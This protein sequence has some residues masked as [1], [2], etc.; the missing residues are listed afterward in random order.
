[1]AVVLGPFRVSGQQCQPQRLAVGIAASAV[2]DRDQNGAQSVQDASRQ[3]QAQ[4][5]VSDH[6]GGGQCQDGNQSDLSGEGEQQG[7][8]QSAVDKGG[9]EERE[10]EEEFV[11]RVPPFGPFVKVNGR[12]QERN[13]AE[14][15]T[16]E[17]D[18]PPI[19]P[20]R[21]LGEEGGVDAVLQEGL[22]QVPEAVDKH[23]LVDDDYLQDELR[24]GLNKALNGP[25]VVRFGDPLGLAVR[26]DGHDDGVNVIEDERNPV[27]AGFAAA[28]AVDASSQELRDD[29]E[30][31]RQTDETQDGQ[32]VD[33]VV[34]EDEFDS[35]GDIG[36]DVR[37]EEGDEEGRE[38]G[39]SGPH[40]VKS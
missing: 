24:Y 30:H 27:G 6:L 23:A 3:V 22:E 10:E 12:L 21:L 4:A 31:D 5:G 18:Q 34:V 1:M 36:E 26:A 32:T 39:M 15:D 37:H 2:S 8:G 35:G 16:V 20:Q 14:N 25:K 17:L 40:S 13:G 7:D 19:P 38:E 33:V 11:Q 28:F 29:R 9:D